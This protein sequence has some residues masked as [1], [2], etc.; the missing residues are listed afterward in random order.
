MKLEQIVPWGRN[1]DEYQQMFALN[2][3]DLQQ[4]ILGCGDGPASFN[5]EMTKLGYDVTSIDPVYEF[6]GAE[7]RDRFIATY[8]TIINQLRDNQ[9]RYVWRNFADVEE[10]AKIRTQTLET[11]LA[12]YSQGQTTGRYL[13]RSLPDTNL[14]D[15][16]FDL[17]LCSHLLFLYSDLLDLEMHQR[18]LQELLR[19]ASEVRIFP[20]LT[21]D[22]QVSPYVEPIQL[23]FS[24]QGYSVEI[25]TV[26]YEFQ[27]GGNQM[28]RI[29]K[30]SRL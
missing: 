20:L 22:G 12:D 28:L 25:L 23:L 17:C 26:D 21:L 8:D 19:V 3:Q 11:F 27:R 10:L 29:W 16:G 7:I 5:A 6:S 1:L 14:P 24:Q 18:S 4:K 15:N 2:S 30:E 13:A 9:S